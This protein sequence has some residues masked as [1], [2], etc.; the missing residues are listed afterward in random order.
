ML[1]Y[2]N[3]K[4]G[5]HPE[6]PESVVTKIVAGYIHT[7]YLLSLIKNNRKYR[8]QMGGRGPLRQPLSPPM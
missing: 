2:T 8:R 5:A 1:L 3:T 7:I 4:V 6:N